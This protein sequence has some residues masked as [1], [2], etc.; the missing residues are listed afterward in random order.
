MQAIASA[1]PLDRASLGLEPDERLALWTGRLDPVKGFEEMLEAASKLKSK[2]RFKLLLAG[3]GPYRPEVERLI[4]RHGIEGR[5]VLLGRRDD[6]GRLLNSADLFVFC[7][8]TE[9]CPTRSWRR[10]R[11][12]CPSCA[13]AWRLPRPGPAMQSGLLVEPQSPD[14][15]AAGIDLLLSDAELASKLGRAAREWVSQEADIQVWVDSWA[16]LYASVLS[17]RPAWWGLSP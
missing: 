14:A 7:S 11:R 8:R 4:A 5:V 2:H 12:G 1:P 13:R 16:S 15:I 3:D 9:A 10:W 17:R 6:V